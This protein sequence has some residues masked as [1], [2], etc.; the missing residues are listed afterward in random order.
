MKIKTEKTLIDKKPGLIDYKHGEYQAKKRKVVQDP[1]AQTNEVSAIVGP[2]GFGETMIAIYVSSTHKPE[3]KAKAHI[4]PSQCKNAAD[5]Y[6]H[7][8]VAAGACAEQLAEQY[9]DRL[10]PAECAR[11]AREVVIEAL[12]KHKEATD[13]VVL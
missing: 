8:E 4:R 1:K 12:M 11:A 3:L 2:N 7:I 13:E 10:D 9:G 6:Y 5:L